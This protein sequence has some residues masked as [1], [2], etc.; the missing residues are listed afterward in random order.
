MGPAVQLLVVFLFIQRK[1]LFKNVVKIK[2]SVNVCTLVTCLCPKKE[3]FETVKLL[4]NLSFAFNSVLAVQF[5]S[6]SAAVLKFVH[7]RRSERFF[8]EQKV[9]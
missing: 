4:E 9:K 5:I 6:I 7:V 8:E 2:I 3:S 1:P